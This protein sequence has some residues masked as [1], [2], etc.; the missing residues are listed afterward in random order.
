MKIIQEADLQNKK[1]LLRVDYN[2]PLKNGQVVDNE[3]LKAS[4][5]T[6]H[7]LLDH[8]ASIVLCSHLGRPEKANHKKYS[9]KPVVGE[10]EKLIKKKVQFSDDC[11]GQKKEALISNLRSG[12]LVLLENLRFYQEEEENNPQF[13]KNLAQGCEVYVNDA[14]SAS[15]RDHASIVG[16]TK[17]LPSYAGLQFQKEV[18]N[19]SKLVDQPQR[20]FVLAMGGAKI[21]DKIPLI[22]NLIGQI[23]S[24][25]LGGAIANT[26]LFAKGYQVGNSLIDPASVELVKKIFVQAR[27]YRVEILL[28]EDCVVGQEMT[29]L[30]GQEKKI[31]AVTD[32]ELI[33]DIG[34]AST[35]RA[36]E[37]FKEAKTIFWNGPMGYAETPAFATGTVALGRAIANSNAFSVIGGGDTV[38]TLTQSIKKHYSYISMA[39]GASL[40]FLSGK[41]L[42]GIKVL[43]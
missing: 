29:S 7:Y 25:V 20:P 15:H 27:D 32:Q 8:Q 30:K 31:N 14:F 10:L 19:L 43:E 17:F 42:P 40:D 18:I 33:L 41:I 36:I 9:L 13:S 35:A 23:D 37:T 11:L 21:A 3:R 22:N 24:L 38:A 26:F 12:Q 1:V 39:G 2:V 34:P 6:I 16:V 28:P 5:E 4:L